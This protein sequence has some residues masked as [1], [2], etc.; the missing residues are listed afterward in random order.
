M[1]RKPD[2]LPDQRARFINPDGTPTP[3]F[4]KWLL[5]AD[6]SVKATIDFIDTP[7]AD[8]TFELIEEFSVFIAFPANKDYRLQLKATEAR[9]ITE[10]VTRSASGTCTATVKVD[11]TALGGSANSVSSSEQSQAHSSSN[12][13]GVGQDIVLTVSS[14]SSCVDMVLTFK[15]TRTITAT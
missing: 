7:V 11:S 8:P 10:V 12:T 1:T 4:F 6:A 15:T 2:P 13:W 9:T 14:N 3:E 5:A